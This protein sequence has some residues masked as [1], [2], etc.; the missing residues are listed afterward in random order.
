MKQIGYGNVY[1]ILLDTYAHKTAGATGIENAV[2][3]TRTI[4]HSD[5]CAAIPVKPFHRYIWGLKD[6]FAAAD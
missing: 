4:S 1:H 2:V 5:V 6:F 3:R